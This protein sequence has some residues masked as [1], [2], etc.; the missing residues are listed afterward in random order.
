[1]YG[2]IG[3]LKVTRSTGFGSILRAEFRSY[4]TCHERL[5]GCSPSASQEAARTGQR[6]R[7]AGNPTNPSTERA[8]VL[9]RS[10]PQE[11]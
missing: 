7:G 5:D 6:Q 4:F 1:M 8:A 10:H 2:T 11:M 9:F 3:L